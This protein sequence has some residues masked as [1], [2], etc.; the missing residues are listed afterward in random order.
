[1]TEVHGTAR[2]RKLRAF[3]DGD[4]TEEVRP[5]RKQQSQES[6]ATDG[7]RQLD[8]AWGDPA[9]VLPA[10]EPSTSTCPLKVIV[11]LEN[12]SLESVKVGKAGMYQL[13]NSDDHVGLLKKLGRDPS[14]VRPDITHQCLLTLLD[15]PLNKSGRLQVYIRTAK[16]VLIEIHPDTRIPRTL[17]RFSGLMVELLQKLKIR[18]TNSSHPLLKVIRNP[19][20]SHLPVGC[21]KIV[22]T[23]NCETLTKM[24]EHSRKTAAQVWKQVG[25]GSETHKT[26]RGIPAV[27]YVVGAMA[28]GKVEEE[29]AEEYVAISEFP[30]SASTVCHRITSAYEDLFGIV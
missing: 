12:A 5:R 14:E 19:I 1:M 28:H 26:S 29:W 7:D 9:A 16:N 4:V 23:Y 21:R 13:L 30:L 11:L 17:K 10:V 2:K 25:V 22:C 18:S 24:S 3:G 15:S 20:T 27:L 8:E 6:P